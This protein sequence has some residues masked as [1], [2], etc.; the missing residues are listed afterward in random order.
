MLVDHFHR[1]SLV[2]VP[3]NICENPNL[4]SYYQSVSTAMMIFP[5]AGARA[6]LDGLDHPIRLFPA[7]LGACLFNS[8]LHSFQHLL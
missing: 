5:E 3:P 6:A 1:R 4:P 7:V 8:R 2:H